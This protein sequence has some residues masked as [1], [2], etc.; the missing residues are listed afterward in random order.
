VS[1]LSGINHVTFLT[2]GMD[3][4]AA[5]YEEVFGARRIVELPVPEHDGRHALIEIG[6]GATLR[7]SES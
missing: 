5:F 2:A 6:A 1:E 4:L 7:C 3:R